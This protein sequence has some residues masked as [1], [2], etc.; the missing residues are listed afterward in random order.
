MLA[1]QKY[2]TRLIGSQLAY[3]FLKLF[4]TDMNECKNAGLP[5]PIIEYSS[6]GISVTI[7][8]NQFNEKSLIEIG[9]S[10][11]QIK[12]VQYLK[13]NQNITNKIYQKTCEVSKATAIRDLTELNILIWYGNFN[14]LL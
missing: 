4:R 7:L 6:G 12:A 10:A 3:L 13:E 8:K 9:L 2:R 14:A 11:R 5:E 1:L